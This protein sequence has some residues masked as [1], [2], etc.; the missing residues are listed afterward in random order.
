M[1]KTK[2]GKSASNWRQKD[3]AYREQERKRRKTNAERR[4][5]REEQK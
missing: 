4:A 3:R 1:P 5:E 2:N